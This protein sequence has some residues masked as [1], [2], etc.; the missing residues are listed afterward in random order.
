MINIIVVL[1]QEGTPGQLDELAKKF[2]S[3][4][5]NTHYQ[6]MLEQLEDMYRHKVNNH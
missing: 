4:E 1:L 6:D 3:K 5:L 2:G